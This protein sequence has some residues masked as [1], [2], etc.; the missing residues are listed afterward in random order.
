MSA[1]VILAACAMPLDDLRLHDVVP[2]ADL[3]FRIRKIGH[4]VLRDSSLREE[5]A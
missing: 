3:P 2:P 5:K 1:A 4:V